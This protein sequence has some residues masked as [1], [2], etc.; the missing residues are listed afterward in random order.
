MSS[1]SSVAAPAVVDKH[2]DLLKMVNKC[3]HYKCTSRRKGTCHV[4]KEDF[5]HFFAF[6]PRRRHTNTVVRTFC[7]HCYMNLF[8]GSA[9]TVDCRLGVLCGCGARFCGIK[10]LVAASQA[11]KVVCENIQL[12]LQVLAK[13][14]FR[15]T[16]TT[17]RSAVKWHGPVQIELLR[18][19]MLVAA[20]DIVTALLRAAESVRKAEALELAQKFAQRALSL[21]AKGSL[22]EAM[23]LN[24]LGNVA[25]ASSKYD[26]AVAHYEAALKIRK[27]L[28]GDNHADVA[29]VYGNLSGV[30]DNLGRLDEALAMCSSALEIFK[31]SSGD[32]QKSIAMCHS[33]MGITLDR[34]SKHEEAMEHFST[35]LAILMKTEGE[36][37]LAAIFL[38]N[39]GAVLKGQNKLDEAMEKLTS[40]LRISEKAKIDTGVATCLHNIASVLEKQSKLDAALEHARKSLAI[41]RSKLSIE[42]AECGESHWLI[43]AILKRSGKFAEALDEYDNTLR[44]RKNV[45]GEMTLQVAEVYEFKAFCFFK[46]EKWREAVTFIEA[47]IHIRT[48]L[49]GA[50]DAR[51]VELKAILAEAEEQLKAERSSAAASERK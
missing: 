40:A 1:S 50:E 9:N 29:R 39:M 13:S 25:N 45:F 34:Q 6:R 27:S 3:T 15:A 51:L 42:H 32:N 46:L 19:D 33:S 16:A 48:V 49:L 24:S 14:Q 30:F 28:Q 2:A 8:D 37:A 47:T 17:N 41:R 20:S 4:N 31:K 12:A 23:A 26:A 22:D 10:C 21:S 43:G 35:G 38:A 7:M 44:I 5:S 11:H 36:T 18:A